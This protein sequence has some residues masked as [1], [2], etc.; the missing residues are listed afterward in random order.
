[1]P[2]QWNMFVKK[3][4]E[5]GHAKD[6]NYQFK[7]ALKDAS[8][9]KGEMSKMKPMAATRRMK[10]SMSQKKSKAAKGGADGD[11]EEMM[12]VEETETMTPRKLSDEFDAEMTEEEMT[13]RDLSSEF[14]AEEDM[15]G[16]K[17]RK[18]GGTGNAV[19][20][21]NLGSPLDRALMAGGK[22]GG[23][24][25]AKKS[26]KSKKSKKARKTRKTRKTRKH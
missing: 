9:R 5:E 22:K 13:P 6:S 10:K 24:K 16:G 4:Y 14:D 15:D 7:D 1:M 8:K 17:R 25:T 19:G 3:V 26:K 11:D 20:T 21:G 2:S 12:E 23:K 18:R